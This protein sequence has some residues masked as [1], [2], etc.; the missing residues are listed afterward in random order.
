[1]IKDQVQ[2]AN[3]KINYFYIDESGNINNNSNVFIHGCIKTDRP[4]SI[5]YALSQ[6]KEELLDNLYYQDFYDRILKE[7]FHATENNFD[8]RADVYKLLPLLEY[9]AYLTIIN[10]NSEYFKKLTSEKDEHEI[11]KM[12]LID[13]LRDRLIKN[14]NDKNIFCFETIKISKKSLDTILSEIFCSLTD[15][16]DCEYKIVG[17]EEENMGVVD[18]VNFVFYHLLSDPKPMK[19]MEQNF[20]LIAPKIGVIHILNNNTF[21]SR[22]KPKTLQI[23]LENLIK[24]YGGSTE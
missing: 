15:E 2:I 9:R 18:Y 16:Y 5:R 10:K 12:S 21:L 6:L 11:F 24:V 17:K 20:N 4:D 23:N 3:K 14:K 13:L 22:K 1:M 8:M 7:G 19:R